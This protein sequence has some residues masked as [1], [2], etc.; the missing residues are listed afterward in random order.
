[1][2]VVLYVLYTEAGLASAVRCTEALYGGTVDQLAR[3][4][5]GELASLFDN[6][7]TCQLFLDPGTTTLF[8]VVMKANC[9]RYDSKFIH[10]FIHSLWRRHGL[11]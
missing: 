6:A 11:D 3:L 1:M 4:S 10:S 2:H 9:F 7:T 5:A 8:D